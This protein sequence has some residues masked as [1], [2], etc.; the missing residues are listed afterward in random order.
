MHYRVVQ[1]ES[2]S[3]TCDSGGSGLKCRLQ[4]WLSC[5]H[6][7]EVFRSPPGKVREW[8]P[9]LGHG[10]FVHVFSNLLFTVILSLHP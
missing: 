3:P 7:F 8:Y 5:F 6:F 9:K 10:R 2:S 4:A 1:N